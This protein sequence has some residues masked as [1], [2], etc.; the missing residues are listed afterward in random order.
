MMMSAHALAAAG[1]FT[2]QPVSLGLRARLAAVVEPDPDVDAAV[3]QVQR[4]R[5]P[6]RSVSQDRD[7]AAAKERQ[8]GIS[9]VINLEHEKPLLS[10]V[11]SLVRRGL[12]RDTDTPSASGI[13][14]AGPAPVLRRALAAR[15]RDAPGA[16]HFE[17]AVRTQHVEQPVNLRFRSRHLEHHRFRRHVD[18]A[19]AEDFGQLHDLRPALAVGRRP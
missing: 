4:M 10:G 3:A 15:H 18:D 13:A 2:T 7:L 12:N 14:A 17:H 5:V 8:V 6:L 9:V 11:T 16:N 19:G 1:S